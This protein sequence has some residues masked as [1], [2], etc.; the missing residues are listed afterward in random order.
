[1]SE[2]IRLRHPWQVEVG[3]VI[4]VHPLKSVAV[5]LTVTGRRRI[6][7]TDT[8]LDYVTDYGLEGLI[9]LDEDQLVAVA[10]K[11]GAS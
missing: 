5:R 3:Q 11:G 9:V 6:T 10:A 8:G 2:P 1:M 4:V 7:C